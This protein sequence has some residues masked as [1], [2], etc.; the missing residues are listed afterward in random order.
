MR[1]ASSTS[2]INETWPRNSS[3]VLS[4]LALYSAY[5]ST[6]KVWRDLSN[7]TAMCVGS[8]SRRT[9]MSIAVKP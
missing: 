3:G 6:R 1:S 7:A 5:S 8:S 2:L 9:L 4:R